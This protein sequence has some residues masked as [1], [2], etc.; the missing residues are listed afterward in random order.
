MHVL[1]DSNKHSSRYQGFSKW[2]KQNKTLREQNKYILPLRGL[3]ASSRARQYA[4][5]KSNTY[6]TLVINIRKNNV[7]KKGVWNVG[8]GG[9]R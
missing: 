2:S 1:C 6:C 5:Q 9:E 4:R 3:N 7:K 8:K